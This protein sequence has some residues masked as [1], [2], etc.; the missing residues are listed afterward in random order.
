MRIAVDV[1]CLN[2]QPM[3]G[4]GYYTRDLFDAFARTQPDFALRLFASGA[5]GPSA[6]VEALGKTCGSLAFM[7]LPTRWKTW[8][9]TTLEMPRMDRRTGPVDM[10]HGAFHL[11]PATR[12]I[13]RVVTIFDLTGMRLADTHTAS[14]QRTHARYLKHAAKRAD[15]IIAISQSCRQDV[16]ELLGVAPARVH[17]VPGGVRLEDFQH[18][19]DV[20]ALARAK[21]KFGIDGDYLIHLGT[22]EPR[23]NLPRLVEAYAKVW[24]ARCD[25][26]KLVLAGKR[27]WMCDPVFETIDRLGLGDAVIETGYLTREEAVNLLRGAA[28]C[29]YPSLYEGFGLPVLEAMAAGVPVLTSNL[30]SLPEVEGDAAVY[31]EPASVSSIAEGLERLLDEPEAR[32]TRVIRGLERAKQFTWEQSAAALAGVYRSL[33]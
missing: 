3:T 29:T 28:A 6:P 8:L 2:P 22:I 16:I 18:P 20:D 4:V 9:W 19:L 32:R 21:H 5:R 33:A 1:S 31:V 14:S 11:L 13:P 27:G 15:A 24:S 17:V 25:L 23:K 12:G 7:R 10:A 26:P 30:S